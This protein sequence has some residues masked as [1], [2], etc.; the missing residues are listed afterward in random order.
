MGDRCRIQGRVVSGKMCEVDRGQ[1]RQKTT[2]GLG[3]RGKKA[4]G[5][6]EKAQKKNI[7]I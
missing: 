1:I 4:G 2:N 6:G 7:Y 5:V 3:G